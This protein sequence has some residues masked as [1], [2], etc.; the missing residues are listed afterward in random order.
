MSSTIYSQ[1]A[2]NKRLTWVIVAFF[3]IFISAL[4]YF[5]GRIFF[6]SGPLFYVWALL[7][8]V[9]SGFGGYYYSD[10]IVLATVG[11]KEI[12]KEE[13]P[14]IHNLVENLCIGAGMPMPR[15][16]IIDSP[17]MNAFATGRD[18]KNSVV[19]FTTGIISGL[20]KLEL[21]GVTAHELSHIAN[22][23][24]RLMAIVGVLVGSITLL[25]DMV[26]R[27]NLF[28]RSGKSEK[29]VGPLFLILGLAMLILSP[30]VATLIKLAIS[31][32]REYLA[33]SSG[34][35]LTRFP[36]GLADALTKISQDANSL[37][38]A[39]TATAHLFI[40]NPFK[41]SAIRGIFDTHPPVDERIK[42]LRDM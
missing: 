35:L 19:C 31:R 28:G 9:I 10:K 6:E 1:I 25:F 24:I 26:F 13:N 18:P 12:T 42:R 33:D 7:F 39:T 2:S 23:D 21:E 20:T 27:F 30:I 14:Y 32:R 36:D 17:A 4:A 16:F 29:G 40:A 37:S 8:S 5:V 11:A 41:G 34:A 22:Y 38:S 3:I 15:I